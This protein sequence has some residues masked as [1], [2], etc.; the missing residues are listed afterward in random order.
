M[1]CEIRNPN[2]IP[3]HIADAWL[4]VR[5]DRE[6]GGPLISDGRLFHPLY[7]MVDLAIL[8]TGN[9]YKG[10]AEITIPLSAAAIQSIESHRNGGDLVLQID[11][12]VLLCPVY[13]GPA[14]LKSV[15][16]APIESRFS[17]DGMSGEIKCKIPQSEWVSLLQRLE[18]SEIEL[19]ELPRDFLRSHPKLARARERLK[20]AAT[21][22]ARGDWEG[23]LQDCRKA[24]EAI[25]IGL[26]GEED[27]Q[28]A[29]PKLKDHF[30]EGL[31]AE[32]LNA[33]VQAFNKF[34][35]L[36]RHEQPEPISF[37]RTDSVL[38]LRITA[39]LMD[40]LAR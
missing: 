9:T 37:D 19:L 20:D 14:G 17:V 31:K 1:H 24:F 29:L 6:H 16:S 36:G 40:Y 2:P 5:L 38:T 4:E 34:L 7:N 39:S 23:V 15:L 21:S 22:L 35:H 18:W 12:R 28:S 11:S 25:A 27:H 32:R 10:L 33:I 30:G 3:L 13:E 26:T 8:W